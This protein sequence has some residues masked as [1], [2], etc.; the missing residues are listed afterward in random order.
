M[1]V[2]STDCMLMVIQ[3]DKHITLCHR[4]KILLLW[5]SLRRSLKVCYKLFLNPEDHFLHSEMLTF[6][7]CTKQFRRKLI[8]AGEVRLPDTQADVVM[9]CTV[10][11][12]KIKTETL[13]CCPSILDNGAEAASRFS[14]DCP[15]SPPKIK[16]S[17]VSEV[18]QH[19]SA[20]SCFRGYV[21]TQSHLSST[22]SLLFFI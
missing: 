10:Y 11:Y 19:A 4:H 9:H 5:F 3:T 21:L 17:H 6:N 2:S 20:T 8:K 1:Q 12:L 15:V 7:S 16:I 18:G 14:P 13:T 22:L